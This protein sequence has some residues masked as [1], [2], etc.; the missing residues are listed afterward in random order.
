ME[1]CWTPKLK[2]S[3]E[4]EA[5][6]SSKFEPQMINLFSSVSLKIV[7]TIFVFFSFLF[8]FVTICWT[9]HLD[10]SK[11]YTAIEWIEYSG[12]DFDR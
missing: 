11:Y 12:A 1:N 8:F 9:S 5:N 4:C 2:W 10:A 3:T 6:R 7:N